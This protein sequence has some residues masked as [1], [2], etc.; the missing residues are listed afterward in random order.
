MFF[1][2]KLHDHKSCISTVTR[3][4]E[5]NSFQ[6]QKTHVQVSPIQVTIKLREV[7]NYCSSKS[8]DSIQPLNLS[9]FLRADAQGTINIQLTFTT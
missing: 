9:G 7:I 8:Y 5:F 1:P 6:D 4:G 2:L 3:L